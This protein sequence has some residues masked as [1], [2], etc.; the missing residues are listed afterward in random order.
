MLARARIGSRGVVGVGFRPA[1]ASTTLHT[2]HGE[3]LLRELELGRLYWSPPA[4]RAGPG[5]WALSP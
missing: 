4:A 3:Q 1:C 2:R 5:A